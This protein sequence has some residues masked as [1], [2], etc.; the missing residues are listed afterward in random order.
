MSDGD[1]IGNKPSG[2]DEQIGVSVR[3]DIYW[4]VNQRECLYSVGIASWILIHHLA[5]T[6]MTIHSC[7]DEETRLLINISVNG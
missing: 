4:V 5:K 3:D 2:V 7:K 6:V 1:Q